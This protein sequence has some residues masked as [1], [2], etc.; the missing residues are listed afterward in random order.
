VQSDIPVNERAT[1]APR[2]L[3][4]SLRAF[5]AAVG[6]VCLVVSNTIAVRELS[7]LRREN[8]RLRDE[9]GYLTIDDPLQVH[10]AAARSLEELQWRWRVYVPP[11]KRIGVFVQ[12]DQSDS[13]NAAI[14]RVRLEPGENSLDVAVVAFSNVGYRF[15]MATENPEQGAGGEYMAS[16]P[17]EIVNRL[18]RQS[19]VFTIPPGKTYTVEPGDTFVLVREDFPETLLFGG[20]DD[21]QRIGLRLWIEEIDTA[22]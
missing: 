7:E 14:N 19:H 12:G 1:L 20:A 13:N 16:M 17:E 11:G 3:R 21:N 22:R 15:K 8:R 18:S 10:V 4:F 5:L 2:R 6:V 9:L